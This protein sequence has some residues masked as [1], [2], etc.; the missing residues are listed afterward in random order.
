MSKPTNVKI[1][2]PLLSQTLDL[3]ENWDLSGYDQ[4]IQRDF[5]TV[6]F[7]LLKKRQ[8]LELRDAYARIIFA[9]DD[10]ARFDAR[11]RYLQQKRFLDNDF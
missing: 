9:K 3:L 1:P 2:L 4:S 8:S 5:D 10:D 6:Y 7:A 11:M